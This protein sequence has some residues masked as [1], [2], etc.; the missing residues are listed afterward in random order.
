MS[1][2]PAFIFRG[3]GVMTGHTDFGSVRYGTEAHLRDALA[4]VWW[5]KGVDVKTEVDVPGCG[6]IDV[7]GSVGHIR[8][9]VEL[10]KELTTP[11]AAR[12]AFMQAHSYKAFLDAESSITPA[13]LR[14]RVFA[15]VTSGQ[16]D[17][18]A[19]EPSYRAFAEVEYDGFIEAEEI[20]ENFYPLREYAPLLRQISIERRA[21]VQRVV[22]ALRVGEM[23]LCFADEER[24]LEQLREGASA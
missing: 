22:D 9:V 20:P 2:V 24:S 4:A 15:F 21:M 1:A 7:L 6:R 14:E 17:W 11:S 18:Q 10:K 23:S 5:F 12:K 3:L 13:T 19:I 16:A 8:M